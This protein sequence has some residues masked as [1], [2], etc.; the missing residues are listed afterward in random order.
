MPQAL[1]WVR[2]NYDFMFVKHI[3]VADSSKGP[4]RPFQKQ[5]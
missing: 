5:A 2:V 3:C 1:P 4:K